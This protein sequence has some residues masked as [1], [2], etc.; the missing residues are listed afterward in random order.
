MIFDGSVMGRGRG[1]VGRGRGVV[2]E[3]RNKKHYEA[4]TDLL[5]QCAKTNQASVSLFS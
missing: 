4:A 5:H 3:G 1:V 2:G